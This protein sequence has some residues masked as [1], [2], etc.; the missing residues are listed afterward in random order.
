[1][2]LPLTLNLNNLLNG[3]R[4][5]VR[6]IS[7]LNLV[8]LKLRFQEHVFVVRNTLCPSDMLISLPRLCG[9]DNMFPL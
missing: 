3:F 9:S 7:V 2:C 8:Q 4:Y 1:M 6:T 5:Q